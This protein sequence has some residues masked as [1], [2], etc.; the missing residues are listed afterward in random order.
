MYSPLGFGAISEHYL[1]NVDREIDA[2]GVLY[3]LRETIIL[4]HKNGDKCVR[5]GPST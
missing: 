2:C 3:V 5:K 1:L 4:V